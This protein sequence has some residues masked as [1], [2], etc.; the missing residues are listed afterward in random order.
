M[1]QRAKESIHI[2]TTPGNLDPT[3][4]HPT[5]PDPLPPSGSILQTARRQSSRGLAS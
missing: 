2:A 3:M 5:V 1:A 4:S